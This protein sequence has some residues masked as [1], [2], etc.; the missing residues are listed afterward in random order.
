MQDLETSFPELNNQNYLNEVVSESHDQNMSTVKIAVKDAQERKE[1]LI[2]YA[3]D[4]KLAGMKVGNKPV[5]E[6]LDQIGKE[7]YEWNK[8]VME[9]A[10]KVQVTF[11]N[12]RVLDKIYN[13][14][15]GIISNINTLE[16][17]LTSLCCTPDNEKDASFY[18][19]EHDTFKNDYKV[20]T[21]EQNSK[22]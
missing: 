6:V 19:Q 14:E 13:D 8:V 22:I 3:R 18:E 7:L 4:H 5:L 2:Q 21:N 15:Q 12:K 16:G 10:R 11:N 20:S 9:F 17:E 1:F